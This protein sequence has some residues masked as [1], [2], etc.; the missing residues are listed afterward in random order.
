MFGSTSFSLSAAPCRSNCG[1]AC[2]SGNEGGGSH[3]TPFQKLTAVAL[4][5]Y[6]TVYLKEEDFSSQ[7]WAKRG[8]GGEEW[9]E[10]ENGEIGVAEAIYEKEL[11]PP[12]RMEAE[13]FLTLCA[14]H[15]LLG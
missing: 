11:P 13:A 6:R 1:F 3:A 5:Y 7:Y 15:F 8:G 2:L 4:L 14:F 12:P 10:G 9:L